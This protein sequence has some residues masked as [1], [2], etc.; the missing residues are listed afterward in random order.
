VAKTPEM[1]NSYSNSIVTTSYTYT[2]TSEPGDKPTIADL[3]VIYVLA[4][5]G[6][7]ILILTILVI[8]MC[9]IY[10]CVWLPKRK[11]QLL[12]L[13]AAPPHNVYTMEDDEQP[14]GMYHAS[15][16]QKYNYASI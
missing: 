4:G 13:T 1:T 3:D 2:I 5:L 9:T 15:S 10:F 6:G 12:T 14:H 16:L 8:T 7:G 11:R